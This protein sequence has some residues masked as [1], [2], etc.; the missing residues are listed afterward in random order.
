MLLV[1]SESWLHLKENVDWLEK[2]KDIHGWCVVYLLQGFMLVCCSAV[3]CCVAVHYSMGAG[4]CVAVVLGHTLLFLLCSLLSQVSASPVAV[5]APASVE[6]T[7][8]FK[9]HRKTKS[10]CS[11][12]SFLFFCCLFSSVCISEFFFSLKYRIIYLCLY[13]LNLKT[14][15]CWTVAIVG[16]II[17][18][19][20][21]F[22]TLTA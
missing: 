9:N 4:Q 20:I 22:F 21:N 13:L 16:Y 3:G 14:I 1:L 5:A 6:P 8:K 11:A 10:K 19:L 15:G 2:S 7:T 18:K 17:I 12:V